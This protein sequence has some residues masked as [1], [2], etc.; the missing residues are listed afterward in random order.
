MSE[1]MTSNHFVSPAFSNPALSPAGCHF[2]SRV[3]LQDACLC[4]SGHHF[5][6]NTSYVLT[7]IELQ[8]E[9]RTFCSCTIS[10]KRVGTFC[11]LKLVLSIRLFQALVGYQHAGWPLFYV[12]NIQ[13][14]FLIW[15]CYF[16]VSLS[17][18]CKAIT[19]TSVLSHFFEKPFSLK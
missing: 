7:T 10:L 8:S 5:L 12:L 14:T 13:R 17:S 3:L 4:L 2:S 18:Y 15:L 11:K 16:I 9:V 6:H 19:S 1:F